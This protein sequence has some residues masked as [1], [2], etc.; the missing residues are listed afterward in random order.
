MMKY[1]YRLSSHYLNGLASE[2]SASPQSWQSLV[3]PLF[4]LNIYYIHPK[5]SRIAQSSRLAPRIN[6]SKRRYQINKEVANYFFSSCFP[7]SFSFEMKLLR[8]N[9]CRERIREWMKQLFFGHSFQF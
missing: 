6:E 1:Y 7:F 4:P 3:L 8:G 9:E 2:V 5:R